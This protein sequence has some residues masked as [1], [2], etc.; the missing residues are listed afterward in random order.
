VSIKGIQ[1]DHAGKA[2]KAC[3]NQLADDGIYPDVIFWTLVDSI[4]D[5]I[6]NEAERDAG[7]ADVWAGQVSDAMHEAFGAGIRIDI[8]DKAWDGIGSD[9]DRWWC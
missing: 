8:I 9:G 4:C 1:Y 5:D 2:L 7:S 6:A 3:L